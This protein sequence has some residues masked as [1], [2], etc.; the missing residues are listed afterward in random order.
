MSSE[1][2]FEWS[3]EACLHAAHKHD[4][5]V[6]QEAASHEE[7]TQLGASIIEGRSEMNQSQ[8]NRTINFNTDDPDEL[9]KMIDLSRE[10]R[11]EFFAGIGKAIRAGVKVTVGTD[12]TG[13]VP[14]TQLAREFATLVEAG[15]TP[16]Q[17]IQAGTRVNAELLGWDERLGT[18]ETGML[19]DII[20]VAGDPSK[21]ISELERVIFVMKDGAVIK[22]P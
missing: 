6:I 13:M 5:K 2:I 12:L 22:Q 15:M 7:M 19:A 9:Q 4:Q 8:M 18:L 16:M 17:A 14:A 20:A 10:T 1:D 21:D 11:P 3:V